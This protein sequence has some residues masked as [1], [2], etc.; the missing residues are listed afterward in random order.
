M[1]YDLPPDEDEAEI[2]WEH[3][4]FA[5]IKIPGWENPAIRIAR[6]REE[7]EE[8]ER[9]LDEVYERP[10]AYDQ[11][12]PSKKPAPAAAP[13]PAPP[14]MVYVDPETIP[15]P[16]WARDNQ[17]VNADADGIMGLFDVETDKEQEA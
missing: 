17:V 6:E 16:A 2:D 8:R 4:F 5:A 9:E 11:E 15:V 13:A 14:K 1:G 10:G 7:R 12:A 3:P